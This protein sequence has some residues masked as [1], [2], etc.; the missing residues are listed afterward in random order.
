MRVS[1]ER[2]HDIVYHW[3]ADNAALW[4][5]VV[6]GI[7]W[8]TDLARQPELSIK[9]RTLPRLPVES[10]EQ[11]GAML[12]DAIDGTSTIG[13]FDL[14][15]IAEDGFRAM[16]VEPSEGRVSLID[17]PVFLESGG[18][19]PVAHRLR[20]FLVQNSHRLVYGFV[21]HGSHVTASLLGRSLAADWPPRP[22]FTA[23][24]RKEAPFEEHYV[25]DAFAIQLLG[26]C[27]SERAPAEPT[28]RSTLL[29]RARTL[30][31]HTA[32]AAWFETSFAPF[33]GSRNSRSPAFRAP[34]VLA[35]ARVDF[36]PLL[37][38]NEVARKGGAH[39]CL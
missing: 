9:V 33:G 8:C 15:A 19:Q 1:G 26:P 29:P 36:S 31:E 2:Y 13:V 39:P 5:L 12:A 23:A 22:G 21:K 20:E 34:P 16:A 14:T 25:P 32:P 6:A 28:W 10:E 11:L 18:W 38:R 24:L 4:D 27:H 17:A 35:S 30:V 7:H 37:F 3:R